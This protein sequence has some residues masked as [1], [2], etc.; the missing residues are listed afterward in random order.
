MGLGLG[1]CTVYVGLMVLLPLTA[2]LRQ[3]SQL[4]W[5]GLRALLVAPRVLAAFGTSFVCAAAA[6]GVNLVMGLPLAW[7]LTRYRF[8]GRRLLDA[9]LDL[10]LALPTAVA[11]ITLTALFAP[12]GWLGAPLARLGIQV[13]GTRLGIVVALVFVGLPFIVR[14]VQPVLEGLDPAYEEAAACLGASW[15]QGLRQVLWPQLRG[16]ALTGCSLAFARALGEYGS[17]IFIA[18]G[19][20]LRTEIAPRLVVARLGV[21]DVTGAAA[22]GAA[23]LGLSFLF[24]LMANLLQRWASASGGEL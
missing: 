9:V 21:G 23:M 1:L 7:A 6:A 5:P 11:G 20:P 15:G 14:T 4:G 10:P 19:L 13:V 22:V 3:A 2:L 18:G 8:P 12:Q 16:S 24:L 17:V